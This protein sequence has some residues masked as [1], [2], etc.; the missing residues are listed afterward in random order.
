MAK[1]HY[2]R[3]L[4]SEPAFDKFEEEN[5]L[6]GDPIEKRCTYLMSFILTDYCHTHEVIS[7]LHEE[8]FSVTNFDE[9]NLIEKVRILDILNKSVEMEAIDPSDLSLEE[10]GIHADHRTLLFLQMTNTATEIN[11]TLAAT[12][13]FHCIEMIKVNSKYQTHENDVVKSKSQMDW[14]TGEESHE[15]FEDRLCLSDTERKQ[16]NTLIL[17]RKWSP[18]SF[19]WLILHLHHEDYSRVLNVIFFDRMTQEQFQWIKGQIYTSVDDLVEKE[20][21]KS[22]DELL[23]EFG[24]TSQGQN[25]PRV[26]NIMQQIDAKK[27]KEKG[28]HKP[29]DGNLTKL[30]HLDLNSD[31]NIAEIVILLSNYVQKTMAHFPRNNQLLTLVVLLTSKAAE[32]GSLLEVATGEG[33]SLIIAMFAAIQALRGNKVDIVTSSKVLARRDAEDEKLCRFYKQLGLTSCSIPVH[34]CNGQDAA[35]ALIQKKYENCDIIYGTASDFAADYL[36]HEFECRNVRG[37]RKFEVVIVDEVDSITIDNALQVTYLSHDTAC[38]RHI[39]QLLAATW[40]TLC[41]Y[42]PVG[43][44][45]TG[46]TLWVSS[47]QFIHTRLAENFADDNDA[48]KEKSNIIL[49]D[50]F[51]GNNI[52]LKEIDALHLLAESKETESVLTEKDIK[53]KAKKLQEKLDKI[54]Q[55]IT[56]EEASN[57]LSKKP[58]IKY[59]EHFDEVTYY[60]MTGS[61]MLEKITGPFGEPNGIES[62]ETFHR[63]SQKTVENGKVSFLFLDG[64]R[65][66]EVYQRENLIDFTKTAMLSRV[67]Y[68]DGTLPMGILSQVDSAGQENKSNENL[69]IPTYLKDYVEKCFTTIVENAL[70]AIMMTEGRDYV[71]VDGREVVSKETNDHSFDHVVPVDFM[72]TGVLEKD[73]KWG[74]GLQQFLEF[75]HQLAISPMSLVT[76]FLSNYS[77]FRKYSHVYGVS[78]TLGDEVEHEFLGKHFTLECSIIPTHRAKKLTQHSMIQCDGWDAWKKAICSRVK[79]ITKKQPVLLVSEDLKTAKALQVELT[80]EHVAGV[81]MYIRNDVHTNIIDD[82]VNAGDIII[83]TTLGGRGTNYRTSSEVNKNGGLFVLMT[84]FPYSIRVEKQMIGRTARQGNTGMSQFILNKN[85][86][87]DTYHGCNIQTMYFLR[88]QHEQERIGRMEMSDLEIVNRQDRLFIAF[89]DKLKYFSNTSYTGEEKRETKPTSRKKFDYTTALNAVKECWAFWLVLHQT[90]IDKIQSSSEE[91]L[92]KDMLKDLDLKIAELLNGDSGNFY[93][94]ARNAMN[95][96]TLQIQ[97]N[98]T[99]E[100]SERFDKWQKLND[101]ETKYNAV[102]LYNQAYIVIK[103]KKHGYIEEAIDLL[104]KTEQS[105]KTYTTEMVTICSCTQMAAKF[106]SY[107]SH[108]GKD[109]VQTNFDRQQLARGSVIKG[110][111]DLI[112]KAK[113]ELISVENQEDDYDVKAK[114]IS[115]IEGADV[116][117]HVMG[118]EMSLLHNMGMTFFFQVEKE[119]KEKKHKFCWDALWC[120]FL[121][122]LQV[123]AGVAVIVFSGGT[124]TSL[125]LEFITEGVSDIISGV[126]GMISGTFSWAQWAVSKALSLAVSLV[127]FGVGPLKKAAKSIWKGLKGAKVAAKKVV[128][129]IKK[130]AAKKITKQGTH[131]L[132]FQLTKQ[133]VG[134]QIFQTSVSWAWD[135]TFTYVLKRVFIEKLASASEKLKTH[136]EIRVCFKELVQLFFMCSSQIT[137]FDDKNLQSRLEQLTE[138]SCTKCMDTVMEKSLIERI[139]PQMNQLSPF[140]KAMHKT[141]KPKMSEELLSLALKAPDIILVIT[142]IVEALRANLIVAERIAPE[143]VIK[144]SDISKMLSEKPSPSSEIPQEKVER[145]TNGLIDYAATKI[146]E[147]LAE[148]M[149]ETLVGVSQ[150]QICSKI[151]ASLGEKAGNLLGRADTLQQLSDHA[152]SRQMEKDAKRTEHDLDKETEQFVIEYANEIARDSDEAANDLHV[153][154][155][156]SGEILP[157]G[158]GIVVEVYDGD[159]GKHVTSRHYEGKPG[160]EPIQLRLTKTKSG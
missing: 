64:G 28:K 93:D 146:T 41:T 130:Q 90:E 128:I 40:C 48:V 25:F 92:K 6:Q 22:I 111:V 66:C 50:L 113:E 5:S 109:E 99:E 80:R 35:D 138:D 91:T 79:E 154:V 152:H 42:T 36:K 85:D 127:G 38:L 63:S 7:S 140:I 13:L 55:G 33:K 87:A 86:L 98:K 134:K 8:V 160:T 158:Q 100:N 65:A 14:A 137:N 30:K 124:L 97:G 2:E 47:S 12:L 45:S 57:L 153:N 106:C 43:E 89:C 76:N 132:A 54:L 68:T 96:M 51:A 83:T 70:N 78:G 3:I 81:R 135:K 53:E 112:S 110:W 94:H 26:K 39:E 139:L 72:G 156:V 59:M 31:E 27:K 69:V 129:Q 136:E 155:I 108:V 60:R 21:Q 62:A 131:K 115:L 118:D 75:K 49:K 11:R 125:G 9:A 15:K 147:K 119:K 18:I 77:F 142:T 150:R 117:D 141:W 102:A 37:S 74:N 95:R 32:K 29:S 123:A 143:L 148:S 23:E 84:F 126:K 145:A 1:E 34:Q 71:L 101:V 133:E 24:A 103:R 159:T 88:A 58:M 107:P 67:R 20:S 4:A 144:V 157:G 120:C 52:A 105:I 104:N 16:M 10:L 151:N 149:V 19:L 44:S 122:V 121:G 114:E 82:E 17:S 46:D 73:K 56:P 116:S 61:G